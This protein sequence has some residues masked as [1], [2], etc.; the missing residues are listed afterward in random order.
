MTLFN[1][2]GVS[3]LTKSDMENKAATEKK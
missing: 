2:L 3:A 1:K